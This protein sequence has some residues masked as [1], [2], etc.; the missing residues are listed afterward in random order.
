VLAGRFVV[1][2]LLQDDATPGNLA[3]AAL[4]LF[5]DAITRRR[6]ETLFARMSDALAMDTG[7]IAATAVL[8]E[9]D[10]ALAARADA[11]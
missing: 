9:L 1:P 6:I 2:E 11:R 5:D 10:R 4:N 7:A 3:Q 8:A